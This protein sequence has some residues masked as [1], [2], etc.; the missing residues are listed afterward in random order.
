LLGGA[1][2]SSSKS[3]PHVRNAN[4]VLNDF[5]DVE[6]DEDEAGNRRARKAP[7]NGNLRGRPRKPEPAAKPL[8]PKKQMGGARPGAGRKPGKQKNDSRTP[9]ATGRKT[10]KKAPPEDT[11]IRSQSHFEA[12][13]V[14]E[15]KDQSRNDDDEDDDEFVDG[16]ASEQESSEEDEESDDDRVRLGVSRYGRAR[17]RPAKMD[18]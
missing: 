9:A 17:G 1:E 10:A 3:A 4:M 14:S 13:Y 8:K 15:D 5:Y 18:L 2:A 16:E 7:A 12:F 11:R 6:D